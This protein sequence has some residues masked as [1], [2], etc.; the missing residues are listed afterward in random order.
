M[1]HTIRGH[2]GSSVWFCNNKVAPG[3]SGSSL[4]SSRRAPRFPISL[5]NLDLVWVGFPTRCGQ[6][7]LLGCLICS[8]ETKDGWAGLGWVGALISGSIIYGTLLILDAGA[9]PGW[10]VAFSLSFLFFFF[11]L[12]LLIHSFFTVGLRNRLIGPTWS[13]SQEKWERS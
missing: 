6:N 8:L 2:R 5:R 12:F 11:A 9:A 13:T 7:G 3:H 1:F 10:L 4:D